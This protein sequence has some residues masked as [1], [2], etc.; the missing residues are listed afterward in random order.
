MIQEFTMDKNLE[1]QLTDASDLLRCA[2]ATAYECGE[3]LK[4]QQRD[5]AMAS[6]HLIVQAQAVI[7]Q[8]IDR[9]PSVSSSAQAHLV[10]LQ[11]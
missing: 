7:D 10:P 5:L 4:G 3:G 1:A 2:S 9:L 11:R 6:R 8:L